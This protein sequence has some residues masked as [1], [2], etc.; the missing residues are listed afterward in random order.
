MKINKFIPYYLWLLM[1]IILGIQ[2][3]PTL[4]N[5][6][7]GFDSFYMHKV[8]FI[9]IFGE[10]LYLKGLLRTPKFILKFANQNKK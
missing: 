4:V 5:D 2:A 6:G 7:W 9:L 3:I 8:L 1:S 10:I